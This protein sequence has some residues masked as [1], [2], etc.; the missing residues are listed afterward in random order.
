MRFLSG[1]ERKVSTRLQDACG[2]MGCRL[3]APPMEPAMMERRGLGLVVTCL[4]WVG[5]GCME[6]FGGAAVVIATEGWCIHDGGCKI[7]WSCLS[8]P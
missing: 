6:A 8:S 5:G 4:S 7:V 1:V 2:M 3:T